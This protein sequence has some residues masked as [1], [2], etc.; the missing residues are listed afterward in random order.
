[1]TN[2]I[3]K[4]DG[5]I[6]KG[7]EITKS[8]PSKLALELKQVVAD[9]TQRIKMDKTI[10]NKFEEEKKMRR[11]FA[12]QVLKFSQ[13]MKDEYVK[14]GKEATTTA[15]RELLKKP[16]IPVD[17]LQTA[18]FAQEL[19]KLKTKASIKMTGDELSQQLDALLAK[20]ND[21]YF[22]NELYD[23]Y[24][25]L[26]ASILAANGDVET[27]KKLARTFEQLESA[28]LTEEQLKAKDVIGYFGD[29][30]NTALFKD[31]LPA[32]QG[33]ARTVGGQYAKYINDGNSGIEAIENEEKAEFEKEQAELL[34]RSSRVSRFTF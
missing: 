26:S 13:D 20:Y 27:R 17:D 34:A 18:E 16:E 23:A 3:E 14:L 28:A 2:I 19:K 30:E 24:D 1:M 32:Y 31:F 4:F 22:A 21:K 15:R 6:D 8:K 5:F 10:Q 12:K 33:I 9:E 25:E 29:F 7:Q 11:D